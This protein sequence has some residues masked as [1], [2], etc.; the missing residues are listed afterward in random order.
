MAIQLPTVPGR[1]EHTN[2]QFESRSNTWNE[3]PWRPAA[4]V[5]GLAVAA[6]AICGL[7]WPAEFVS[8]K[9]ISLAIAPVSVVE[10]VTPA[11]AVPLAEVR[12]G[13]IDAATP[14][15]TAGVAEASPGSTASSQNTSSENPSDTR[16]VSPVGLTLSSAA[17]DDRAAGSEEPKTAPVVTSEVIAARELAPG[18]TQ[19]DEDSAARQALFREF[20]QWQA[21]RVSSVA[22][23]RQNAAKSHHRLRPPAATAA[24]VV[25]HPQLRST[26]P[27]SAAQATPIT[28]PVA[29]PRR[30]H[31]SNT[32]AHAT[33][34]Q[35]A[36]ASAT[37]KPPSF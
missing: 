18:E 16:A 36:P 35:V 26:H 11:P 20:L 6:A 28:S 2:P 21:A 24:S 5:A 17:V 7:I 23:A 19:K 12:T 22:P 30:A 25:A 29:R 13:A 3:I 10:E 1:A 32:Q 37:A 27:S 14:L 33:I 15:S 8:K 4:A 9:S 31:V 34:E